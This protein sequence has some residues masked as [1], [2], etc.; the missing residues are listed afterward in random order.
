MGLSAQAIAGGGAD[1]PLD[2]ADL[3]RCINY[4]ERAGISIKDLRRRMAGRST[5]W[6]RLIP[7]WDHLVRLVRD[8]V[9]TRTDG[10]APRT[11]KAMQRILA[12]GIACADC[13]ST[14]RGTEC[15]KCKGTGRRSGGRCRAAHC[16]WGADFC[17]TCKGRGYTQKDRA[18]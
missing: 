7:E 1:H 8:E 5:A 9:E 13:D 17:P 18:A 12:G 10:T 4:C 14:G 6:D 16:H 3:I 11:F 2:P 15:T